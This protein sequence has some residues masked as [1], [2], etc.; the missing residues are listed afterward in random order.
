[1]WLVHTDVHANTLHYAV[2]IRAATMGRV[3]WATTSQWVETIVGQRRA[4][5]CSLAKHVFCFLFSFARFTAAK[6]LNLFKENICIWWPSQKETRL[7]KE[8]CTV[9]NVCAILL[10]KITWVFEKMQTQSEM[11]SESGFGTTDFSHYLLSRGP[12]LTFASQ[13]R[14]EQSQLTLF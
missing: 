9:V 5:C 12:V 3:A 4:I 13:H 6:V 10:Y 14:S 8:C 7:L 1:M 2:L 11:A